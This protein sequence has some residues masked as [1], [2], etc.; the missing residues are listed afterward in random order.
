[1]TLDLFNVSQLASIDATFDQDDQGLTVL[2]ETDPV[3]WTEVDAVTQYLRSNTL[4]VGH[5][6]PSHAI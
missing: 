3:S 1:M 6:P 4:R 2:P 5:E